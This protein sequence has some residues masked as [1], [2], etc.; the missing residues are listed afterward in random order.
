LS[1]FALGAS[2]GALA[3]GTMAACAGLLGEALLGTQLAPGSRIVEPP[4]LRQTPLLLAVVGL[5]AAVVKLAATA[6]HT[7]GQHRAAF[8]FG[9]AIRAE[10]A[11][12]ALRRGRR[13]PPTRTLATLTVRIRD[14]ERAV[15]EGLLS[16]ARAVAQLAPLAGVLVMLSSGLALAALLGLAPF[17]VALAAARARLRRSRTTAA[18]LAERLHA[19]V[20]ELFRHLDLWRTFGSGGAATA[21]LARAGEAAGSATAQAEAVRAA[22]SGAN[23]VLAAAALVGVVAL[24]EAGRVAASRGSLVAFATVFFMTYR[25]LRDLGDARGAFE[26][27][28]DALAALDALQDETPETRNESTSHAEATPRTW[29]PARLEIEAVRVNRGTQGPPASSFT[30]E[31]GEIVA[32]VGPTGVGKTTLL[33]ALL[34]LEPIAEGRV[35]YG[36]EDL[37]RVGVGPDARPFAWVPQDAAIVAGG[38]EQNVALGLRGAT[39]E[40]ASRAVRA[41]LEV[42]G[43][44]ALAARRANDRLEAG[45]PEL[46]GGERQQIAIARALASGQPVLLL[47]E[48]TSGLDAEA[49]ARVLDALARLRGKRTLILVTHRPEPLGIADRVVR[50]ERERQP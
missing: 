11:A 32:L 50:M 46:S 37:T 47:D 26:R 12:R 18:R 19:A 21:E 38:L 23:E 17:A 43:A 44:G 10:V 27:G 45:G 33:R 31:A 2:L 13:T 16:G 5:S 1:A 40:G 39:G 35:R 41:A 15:D 42:V 14:V 22:L 34:G 28:A 36:G 48:P 4:I 7:Y 24:F 9:D 20:D 3:H 30:A 8:R 29:P 25:P 6:L 49:Q